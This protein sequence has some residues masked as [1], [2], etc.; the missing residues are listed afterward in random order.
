MGIAEAD[1]SL[2]VDGWDA[3][4]KTAA[5]AN[6][7]LGANIT[8]KDVD[9]QGIGPATGPLARD[10]RAAGRRLKLVA[11]A[12]RDGRRITARV[13]PEELRGDDLLAGL[14]GQQNALILKTDVLEEIAIVQ[15]SGSLTQT[16]YALLS[17]LISIG[18]R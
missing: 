12:D 10:A 18:R 16:A 2:D 5:L 4:A 3:A 6:V 13:A 1:P 7:L 17:D 14:E 15:R 9:R 11:R 8:P